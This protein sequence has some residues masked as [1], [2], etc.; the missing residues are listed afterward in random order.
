MYFYFSK[1]SLCTDGATNG[2]DR[3]QTKKGNDESYLENW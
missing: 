3:L 2:D 1:K